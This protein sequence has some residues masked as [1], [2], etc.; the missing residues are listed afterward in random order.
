MLTGLIS[1]MEIGATYLSTEDLGVLE[2]Y[3]KAIPDSND[4]LPVLDI[5]P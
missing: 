2:I 5:P 1:T 3:S 4:L